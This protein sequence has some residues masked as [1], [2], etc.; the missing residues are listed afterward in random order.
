M[1]L[2]SNSGI[3]DDL[4]KNDNTVIQERIELNGVD[5][6][7]INDGVMGGLSLGS[8]KF[9]DSTIV[10][11][12]DISIE[13]NGG[14]SS[15]YRPV[16]GLSTQFDSIGLQVLGDGNLYQVRIRSQIEGYSLTYKVD[17][18]ASKNIEQYLTFKL[19]DFQASF[20]G[21]L[22]PGAPELKPE[23]ITHVGFLVTSK[24]PTSF[25]LTVKGITFYLS[26]SLNE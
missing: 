10:F 6:Q 3:A 15:V 9:L 26:S 21:R 24:Q 16:L 13:N 23:N 22:I 20:R 14:F 11:S 4:N 2:I 17:F 7:V 12:G 18:Y 25:A 5:W 19:S 1:I 8:T